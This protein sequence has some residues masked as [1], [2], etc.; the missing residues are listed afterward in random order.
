MKVGVANEETWGFFNEIYDELKTHY[1][2]SIFR[3]REFKLPVFYTRINRSVYH[4]DLQNFMKT[5]DVVFFEWASELLATATHLRKT[6]RIVTRLHRYEM[7][8]WANHINWDAVDKVILVSKAM[9]EEFVERFPEHSFKSVVS[10]PSTSLQKFSYKPKTFHADI[11]ILCHLTPRKRV[12][13]LILTFYE[14][15]QKNSDFHLHVAGG[16]NSAYEDYYKALHHLVQDLRLQDKV[17]FY[18]HLPDPSDWYSQIDIFVSNSYS[19]G[20]QVAPMEAMASGC[21]CLSHR[22]RGADELLPEEYLFVSNSELQEKIL[23]YSAT[24]ETYKTEQRVFMRQTAC[25]EF[26]IE[27]T[28]RQICSVIDEVGGYPIV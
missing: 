2:T 4:R 11:G 10:S 3:R 6:C 21:Y 12:Y 28:K 18:G 25:R 15:L 24:S 22:W 20:L 16:Q 13:D 26:D 1:Q 8:Q 17:T 23:T 9:Q 27:K 19:E 7:Y 14:L 5:N